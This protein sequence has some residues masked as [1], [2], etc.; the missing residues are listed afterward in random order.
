MGLFR[1][2]SEEPLAVTMAGVKLGQRLLAVGTRDPT[3]VAQLAAKS[4]LTG[5]ACLVDDDASRL[6]AAAAAI[7]REGALIEPVH[8]PHGMWP[9]DPDSFDVA[10]IPQLLPAMRLDD[11]TQC[12]FEVFRV[13]RPGGRVLVVE[14]ARRGGFLALLD[15]TTTSNPTYDGPIAALRTAGFGAVRQLAEA[16]GVAYAE[17]VKRA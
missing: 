10:V 8:A 15:R 12:L 6:T 16:D 9:F 2:S 13:L 17:G 3:L 7:E 1:K 4:G 5:R 11:R 14:A